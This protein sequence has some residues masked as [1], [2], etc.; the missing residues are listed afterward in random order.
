LRGGASEVDG[1]AVAR[2][3][4][5]AEWGRGEVLGVR[6]QRGPASRPTP[7]AP[8]PAPR[9]LRSSRTRRAAPAGGA[10]RVPGK[11]GSPLLPGS[12]PALPSGDPSGTGA[13]KRGP[14]LTEGERTRR[15][16]VCGRAAPGPPGRVTDSQGQ[17]EGA[18]GCRAL[19]TGTARLLVSLAEA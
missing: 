7:R 2:L 8:R 10:S 13:P 11:V 15:L 18:L 9:S 5:S 19:A 12:S 3:R 1:A 17:Q 14:C 6:A 4:E 16:L